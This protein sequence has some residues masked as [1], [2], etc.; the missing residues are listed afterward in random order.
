MPPK[1]W[2]RALGVRISGIGTGGQLSERGKWLVTQGGKEVVDPTL[3]PGLANNNKRPPTASEPVKVQS[4]RL[5]ADQVQMVGLP[6]WRAEMKEDEQALGLDRPKTERAPSSRRFSRDSFST[7]RSPAAG[8][9]GAGGSDIVT[10]ARQ[11]V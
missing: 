2:E 4:P 10:T 11:S 9:G 3:F 5:E 8:E 7:L 1:A 6:S